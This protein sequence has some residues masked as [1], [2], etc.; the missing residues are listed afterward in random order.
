MFMGM[1]SNAGSIDESRLCYD[2]LDLIL[3]GKER[4]SRVYP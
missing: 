1:S 4:E 3:A 2:Q